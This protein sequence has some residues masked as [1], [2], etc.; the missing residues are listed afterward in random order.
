M[1]ATSSTAPRR[2]QRGVSRTSAKC[3][4]VDDRRIRLPNRPDRQTRAHRLPSP[5]VPV[6]RPNASPLDAYREALTAALK[7]AVVPFTAPYGRE[8][9]LVPETLLVEPWL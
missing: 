2:S 9:K 8:L 5:P 6:D 3:R 7:R 4:P 1:A